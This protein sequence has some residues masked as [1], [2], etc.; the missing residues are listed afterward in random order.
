MLVDGDGDSC[1]L[2]GDGSAAGCAVT[3]SVNEPFYAASA[4]A[5]GLRENCC[6]EKR[7]LCD[8]YQD[9]GDPRRL[10]ANHI[11]QLKRRIA[12]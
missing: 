10:P 6:A 2:R 8:A 9:A 4:A 1:A 3:A 11:R 12:T 5:G 7:D